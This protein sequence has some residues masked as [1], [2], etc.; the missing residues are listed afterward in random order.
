M[1]VGVSSDLC[2]YVTWSLPLMKAEMLRNIGIWFWWSSLCIIAWLLLT[3]RYVSTMP[4]TFDISP[5]L[6]KLSRLYYLKLYFYYIF[7]KCY[8]SIKFFISFSSISLWKCN[9]FLNK[10]NLQFIHILT[11]MLKLL[12]HHESNVTFNKPWWE[13]D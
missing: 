8:Y 7:K 1:N 13:S 6:L 4:N 3:F 5:L 9:K 10:N 12:V 11:Q 2:S